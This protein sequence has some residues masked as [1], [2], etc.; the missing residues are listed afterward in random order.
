VQILL[1]DEAV[2]VLVDHVEGFLELLDLRLVEHGE[3]IGGGTLGTLLGGLGFGPFAGHLGGWGGTY[4][5]GSRR[6]VGRAGDRRGHTAP[7]TSGPVPQFPQL[8]HG[9]AT[10]R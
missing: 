9:L 1:V 6:G 5:Q 8:P 4:G 10:A 7:G 2:A 3:D